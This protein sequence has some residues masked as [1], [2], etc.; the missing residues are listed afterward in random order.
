MAVLIPS[1][2]YFTAWI[3]A[4][5]TPFF[6]KILQRIRMGYGNYAVKSL[7]PWNLSFCIYCF[8][9]IASLT[10]FS[11]FTRHSLIYRH[12]SN[13][14]TFFSPNLSW[15]LISSKH[16]MIVGSTHHAMS[17]IRKS[18]RT[19]TCNIHKKK[20]FCTDLLH[21]FVFQDKPL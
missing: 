15:L 3:Y 9:E 16:T 2:I 10:I 21:F 1:Y 6:S 13:S 5:R 12:L 8:L 11:I 14:K 17:Y 18:T 4:T 7:V 19:L 20:F